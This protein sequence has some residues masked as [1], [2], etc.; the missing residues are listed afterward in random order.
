MKTTEFRSWMETLN[1]ISRGQRDLLRDQLQGREM[2]DKG[3]ELI[4]Q[5][6][7]AEPVCP[8]CA[9]IELHRWGTSCGLQRYRCCSCRRTLNALTDTPLARLRHKDKWLN[10]EQA[11]VQGVSLRQAATGCGIS[12]NT[13]FKWRH[14]F[15]CA[16]YSGPRISDS[17]LRW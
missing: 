17:E 7:A 12:K 3:A 9:G 11:M 4:E 13:S 15:L 2:G 16:P 14:R 10:Y 5:S 8:H 6:L 1:R